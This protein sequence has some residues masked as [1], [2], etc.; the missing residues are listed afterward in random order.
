MG[1][2]EL[3]WVGERARGSPSRSASRSESPLKGIKKAGGP[4]WPTAQ[5][6][7]LAAL[8][9]GASSRWAQISR[10]QQC[11]RSYERLLPKRC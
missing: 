6:F 11:Y 9:P 7:V 4:T 10:H 8:P 2:R 1:T 5:R 3:S